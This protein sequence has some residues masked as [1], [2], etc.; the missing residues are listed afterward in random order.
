MSL[1]LLSSTNVEGIASLAANC[2]YSD[3]PEYALIYYRRLLQVGVSS[4]ELF[5]NLALCC[6]YAQQYDM[7]L[8]SF[9][10][11]LALAQSNEALADIWYNISIVTMAVGDVGI[12]YQVCNAVPPFAI[13]MNFGMPSIL[14][15]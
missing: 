4:A 15:R 7:T 9:E 6:F 5:N 12:C 13:V 1:P 11:A 14:R 2:F 10:R 8:G 3:Q